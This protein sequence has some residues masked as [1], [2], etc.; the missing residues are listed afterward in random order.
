M[1]N[2]LALRTGGEQGIFFGMT[3]TQK[4]KGPKNQKEIKYYHWENNSDNVCENE[5]KILLPQIIGDKL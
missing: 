1:N 3:A 4:L 5:Q 2:G